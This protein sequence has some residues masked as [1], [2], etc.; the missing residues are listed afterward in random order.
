MYVN[1]VE[2]H[3]SSLWHVNSIKIRNQ[4]TRSMES[5][6]VYM[7]LP[8]LKFSSLFRNLR[9]PTFIKP[10]YELQLHYS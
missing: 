10:F 9:V 8:I 1:R 3:F 2:W 4:E 5:R 7:Q 6:T